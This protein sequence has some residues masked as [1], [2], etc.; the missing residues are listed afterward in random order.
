MYLVGGEN[1]NHNNEE[2]EKVITTNLYR[3]KSTHGRNSKKSNSRISAESAAI[4]TTTWYLW[5]KYGVRSEAKIY[6]ISLPY[7]FVQATMYFVFYLFIKYLTVIQKQV[8]GRSVVFEEMNL[9]KTVW[10]WMAPKK[11]RHHWGP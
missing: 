7:L 11:S 6:Q 8:D 1:L 3:G 10:V 5:Q 9:G 4:K 2:N